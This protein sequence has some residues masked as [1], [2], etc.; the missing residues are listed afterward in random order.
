MAATTVKF[1][2]QHNNKSKTT[3]IVNKLLVYLKSKSESEKNISKAC[4]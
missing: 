4:P 3:K 2:V 1:E